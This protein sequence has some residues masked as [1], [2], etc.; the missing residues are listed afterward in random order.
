L[1]DDLCVD[2]FVRGS[3]G[4]S[5]TSCTIFRGRLL[6][7]VLGSSGTSGISRADE[8]DLSGKY[9]SGPSGPAADFFGKLF[10]LRNFVGWGVM[11][12]IRTKFREDCPG[13]NDARGTIEVYEEIWAPEITMVG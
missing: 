11:E 6:V 3:S 7:F 2:A 4:H 9:F 10:R 8:H 12:K 13:H 5:G 1:K